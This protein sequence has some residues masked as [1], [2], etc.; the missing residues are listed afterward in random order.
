MADRLLLYPAK[1]GPVAATFAETEQ[2][3]KFGPSVGRPAVRQPVTRGSLW[4][5][6]T[7][8]TYTET[9]S[10]DRFGP[11]VGRP[12][13]KQPTSRGTDYAAN[14]FPLPSTETV[15]PDKWHW[16]VG[17]KAADRPVTRAESVVLGYFAPESVQP[18]KFSPSV[19][20]PAVGQKV[21]RGTLHAGP[22]DT[23]YAEAVHPE[24]WAFV[25][26]P[27]KLAGPT[28]RGGVADVPQVASPPA[29]AGVNLESVGRPKV[30]ALTTRGAVG[31]GG[32][33]SLYTTP[34]LGWLQPVTGWV[35]AFPPVH[36]AG[37]VG[38]GE[39]VTA[40]ADGLPAQW[41]N[42][43]DGG[44]LFRVPDGGVRFRIPD[45]G[46]V[47]RGCQVPDITGGTCTKSPGDVRRYVFSFGDLK[48]LNAATPETLSAAS[49]AITATPAGLT[50]GAASV[51]SSGYEVSAMISGGAAGTDYTVT[52]TAILSG[53][54]TIERS[55][56]LEVR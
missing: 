8:V 33:P 30:S 48:E 50:V 25:A 35:P 45:G 32:E 21:S 54:G 5:G 24:A 26:P 34:P 46:T 16:S 40:V 1:V 19:G 7:D 37:V 39:P 28:A 56:T 23:G 22:V 10:A 47:W 42:L 4:V 14:V 17:R 13:V 15:T 44:T 12:G 52:C 43:R 18:D 20:V 53:G 38:L 6:P 51:G 11:S 41:W 29:P 3:D 2:V 36:H 55:G 27:E 49:G 9:V 31:Y